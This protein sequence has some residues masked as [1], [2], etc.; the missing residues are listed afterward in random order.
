MVVL[1]GINL[2]TFTR[3]V[4]LALAEKGIEYRFE[5][6]AMGSAKIRTLHPLGKIPVLE[7]AGVVVPD[8][9]V[10]IAYLERAYP[11]RP[12]YP[13]E[14]A[15]L[16]RALWLEEYADTRL[17]EATVPFFAER[18]VKPLFLARP[19]DEK[20]L[21]QAAAVR[22]EAFDYLEQELPDEGFAVGQAVSVADIA[23]AAQLITYRQGEGELPAARW[24]RLEAWLARLCERP[25]WAS[26]LAE[27][28]AA[29]DAARSK[30][31]SAG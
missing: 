14:A 1:Y 20:A 21:D 11:A 24:P 10:I 4:R 31:K 27:E 28:S 9:S 18:V 8:S 13:R 17:R 5:Q 7:D 26:I 30:R 16:A 23:I 19:G 29:L 2:S 6:A 15:P 25:A 22:D 3:K 12:L